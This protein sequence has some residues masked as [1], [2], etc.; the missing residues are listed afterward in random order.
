[1]RSETQSALNAVGE[2]FARTRAANPQGQS[3]NPNY[4]SPSNAELLETKGGAPSLAQWRKMTEALSY[5]SVERILGKPKKISGSGGAETW[6]YEGG[7][8][9]GFGSNRKVY[10][11]GGY[12][13]GL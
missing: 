6:F 5:E 2:E 3:A 11:F 4:A 10:G 8:Y 1:L 13:A 9:V 12:S 7:G